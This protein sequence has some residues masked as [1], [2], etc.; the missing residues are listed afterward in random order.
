MIIIYCYIMIPR[1]V[2][3]NKYRTPNERGA[4]VYSNLSTLYIYIHTGDGESYNSAMSH[5][6]A[7]RV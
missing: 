6:V 7:L 1:V 4:G 3:T 5:Q 2:K